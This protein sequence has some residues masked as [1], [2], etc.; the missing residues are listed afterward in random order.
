[1]QWRSRI[2][3]AIDSGSLIFHCQPIFK[4]GSLNPALFEVLVRLV[5]PSGEVIPAARFVHDVTAEQWKAIDRLAVLGTLAHLKN[6]PIPHAVNISGH[7]LNDLQFPGWLTK[8]LEES[9]LSP[10]LLLIEVS[11]EAQI[12]VGSIAMYAVTA[13][14]SL[15]IQVGLDDFTIGFAN[16][17]SLM[18]L[19]P[20]FLKVDGSTVRLI[21]GQ[22]ADTVRQSITY[23]AMAYCFHEKIPVILEFVENGEI[24]MQIQKMAKDFPRLEVFVQGHFE[25]FGEAR[26]C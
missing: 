17:P 19:K 20:E 9:S 6:N 16:I 15:A 12:F 26:P 14:R 21:G 4:L 5:E 18:V 1:M 11:E 23:M 2:D 3:Q 13:I 7:T 8:Q 25:L 10:H 22:D 24:L